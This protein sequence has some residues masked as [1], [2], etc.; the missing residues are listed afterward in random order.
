MTRVVLRRHGIRRLRLRRGI[1]RRS[2]GRLIWRGR[3][4]IRREALSLRGRYA[5]A[6][7]GGHY[8]RRLLVRR[9]EGALLLLPILIQI[10]RLDGRRLLA[11]LLLRR[12]ILL[13]VVVRVGHGGQRSPEGVRRLESIISASSGNSFLVEDQFGDDVRA[14]EAGAEAAWSGRRV[15]IC[16]VSVE[17][18]EK[19]PR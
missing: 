18:G 11:L 3:W 9:G 16:D 1:R 17:G 6:H 12:G 10:L 19:A 13:V 2:K 4:R 8:G 14:V 15:V 7:F 5:A